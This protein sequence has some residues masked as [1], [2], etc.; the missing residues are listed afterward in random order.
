MRLKG[1]GDGGVG[2]VPPGTTRP[3]TSAPIV[4]NEL[5]GLYEL[6]GFQN[7]QAQHWERQIRGKRGLMEGA[8]SMEELIQVSTYSRNK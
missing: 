3:G 5:H 8:Y 4:F 1:L 6:H 2:V 7:K